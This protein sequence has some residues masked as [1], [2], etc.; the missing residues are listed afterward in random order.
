MPSTIRGISREH[1]GPWLG[2]LTEHGRKPATLSVYYRSI[3]PFF[4]WAVDEG[5]IEATPMARIKPPAVPEQPVPVPS[6]SEV[7]AL[8]AI[9]KRDA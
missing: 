5:E 3:Q 4:K 8:L 7:D 1:I 2:A 9:G 6:R